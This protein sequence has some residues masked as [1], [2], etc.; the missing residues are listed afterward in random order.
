MLLTLPQTVRD[1]KVRDLI[2]LVAKSFL[3]GDWVRETCESNDDEIVPKIFKFRSVLTNFL[4]GCPYFLIDH[5]YY[6][7]IFKEGSRLTSYQQS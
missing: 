6:K 7:K 3:E 4:E 2:E 1:K 5:V